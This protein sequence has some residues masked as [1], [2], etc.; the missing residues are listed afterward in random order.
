VSQYGLPSSGFDSGTVVYL[1]FDGASNVSLL[2]LVGE[3]ARGICPVSILQFVY[4]LGSMPVICLKMFFLVFL[5][6]FI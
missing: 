1:V 6:H 5:L 2:S 4:V 3:K